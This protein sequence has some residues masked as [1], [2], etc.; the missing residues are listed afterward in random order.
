MIDEDVRYLNEVAENAIPV[1]VQRL[2]NIISG[3]PLNKSE[4]L[5]GQTAEAAYDIMERLYPRAQHH[6]RQLLSHRLAARSDVPR[7]LVLLL[8]ND[9]IEISSPLIKQNMA[10]VDDDLVSIVANG[11]TAH[12]VAVCERPTLS[13][14]LS[15]ILAYLGDTTVMLA[16]LNNP[17]AQL[18]TAT[19]RRL[20]VA[21]RNQ[22]RLHAPIL[23]RRELDAQLAAVMYHWVSESLRTFITAVFGESVAALVKDDIEESSNAGY[24]MGDP[25]EL[26]ASVDESSWLTALLALREGNFARA[27]RALQ[28]ITGLSLPAIEM[29]MYHGDGRSLAVLCRAFNG[30][31]MMFCELYDRL[32]GSPLYGSPEAQR[33]RSEALAAFNSYPQQSAYELLEQ[34]KS[35]PE[36]IWGNRAMTNMSWRKRKLEHLSP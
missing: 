32:N 16:L 36:T 2:L 21:S 33:Q 29:V 17:G 11:T 5:V 22:E 4:E 14:S 8:A 1:D 19:M 31:R 18:S 6:V 27:E 3:L 34:W 24:R 13:E 7:S 9:D 20:V 10:L 35:Q 28:T 30:S 12:R 23:K 26:A 25:R 15:H